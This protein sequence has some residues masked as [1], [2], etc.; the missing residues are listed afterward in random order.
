MVS[1]R[2]GVSCDVVVV[3]LSLWDSVLVYAI[4]G[5]DRAS[6]T[7]GPIAAANSFLEVM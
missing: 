1:A 5:N 7:S 4:T 6:I 3:L 2:R